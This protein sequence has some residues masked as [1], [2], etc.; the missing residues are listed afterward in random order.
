MARDGQGLELSNADAGAVAALDFVRQE[1]LAFGNRFGDFIAAADKENRCLM[2]PLV[3]A[4]L[5]LSMN[6]PD[7]LAAAERFLAR[8][9]ILAAGANPREQAWLAAVETW[10][11]GDTDRTLAHFRGIVTDWPRDLLAAKLGLAL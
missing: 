1:W 5:N 2:L 7:G 10:I 8:A 6:S 4:S 9:R 11:A 3:A